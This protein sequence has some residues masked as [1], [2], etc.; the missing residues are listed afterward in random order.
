MANKVSEM[1]EGLTNNFKGMI[2]ANSVVGEPIIVND[3]TMIVPISKVSFG[4]G[5]GGCEFD[6][7]K[8]DT[9]SLDDKN[10]GGGMGGGASVD[11]MAFLVI[12]NGNVRLIPME[13]GSSPVDK[14]I[15]LV[16]E[17]VDKVNGFCGKTRKKSTEKAEE[18]ECADEIINQE[19]KM[20][21]TRDKILS[22]VM[23]PTRYTGGEL[24]SVIKIL[25]MLT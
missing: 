23:K 13:G 8:N 19:N 3:G 7:K 14:L 9:Q 25:P 11:A 24:N 17:V 12:N 5:G 16:P 15:D 22:A 18:N 10:F 2:D 4:F 1:F 20:I 6:R 21:T